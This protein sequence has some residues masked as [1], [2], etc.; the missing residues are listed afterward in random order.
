MTRLKYERRQRR[1]TQIELGQLAKMCQPDL[2]KIERGLL[3]PT[4]A[5]GKRIA[6][7]FSLS[8]DDLLKEVVVIAASSTDASSAPGT[9]HAEAAR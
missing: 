9:L 8:I 5:Q 2:S 6:A 3:L 7:V 1:L 4:P